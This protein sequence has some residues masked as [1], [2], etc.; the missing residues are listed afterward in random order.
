MMFAFTGATSAGLFQ[1]TGGLLTQN[2]GPSQYET[3]IGQGGLIVSPDWPAPVVVNGQTIEVFYTVA[4]DTTLPYPTESDPAAGLVIRL[5]SGD[6][7]ETHFTRIRCP[8][9]GLDYELTGG[10]DQGGGTYLWTG[11]SADMF[12]NTTTNN[13]EILF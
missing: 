3:Y 9:N 13:I 8:E 10:V 12:K 6:N 2:P 1:F 4:V 5:L 7:P 11:I